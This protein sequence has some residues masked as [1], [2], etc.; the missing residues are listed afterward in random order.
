MEIHD[1]YDLK[2]WWWK[3]LDGI[4]ETTWPGMYNR[5]RLPGRDDY[6]ELP[7]WDCYS[8]SGKAIT[9]VM[10]DEPWN[11]VEMSGSAWGKMEVLKGDTPVMV[12]TKD[13]QS[14]AEST[15]FERPKGQ[16]K[17]V[18]TGG[19]AHRA[20]KF[21]FTNVEQEEPIGEMSVY[22]VTAG[23]EP[24]G[25]AKLAFQLRAAPPGRLWRRVSPLVTF[26]NGRF[27]PDERATLYAAGAAAGPP[28]APPAAGGEANANMPLVHILIPDSWDN[29]DGGLDG[30][31]IDLPALNVKATHGDLF[32]MNIQVKDPLWIY[33]DMLDFTFS[34]RPNQAKTLWLDL[35]DRILPAN[36]PLYITIAGAGQDF[37]ADSLKGAQIRLVF[38]PREAARAEHELDRFTQA[39]DCYAMLVEEHPKSDRLNMW[40]RF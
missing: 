23:A 9:F 24:A 17:T 14:P 29:V 16:E 31:A 8:V 19:I 15:L 4:R 25:S 5:S 10:P 13:P 37:G 11:H 35:R 27:P 39:R 36:L 20:E 33:R 6:F 34:V 1:A 3:G 38:K 12:E 26:I 22:N 28:T 2:R 7:D 32:P 18:H 30:I 21:R 40:V